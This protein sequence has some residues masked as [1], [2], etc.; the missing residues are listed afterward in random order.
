MKKSLIALAVLA[1]T[2]SAMAQ[3][4]VTLSGRV[5]AALYSLTTGVGSKEVTQTGIGNGGDF[6]LTGSRWA[7]AGT[8]DLGGGL[9]AMFKLENRFSIDDGTSVG[10]FSGDAFVALAG[11]FGTV[12]LGRTYTAFDDARALSNSANVFD[13]A[14]TP[15]AFG[16]LTTAGVKFGSTDYTSRGANGVRYESPVFSGISGAVSYAFDENKTT[17]VDAGSI[18]SLHVKYAAGPLTVAYGYQDQ[19]AQN[20]SAEIAPSVANPAGTA[21]VAAT[22]TVNTK[23]HQLSAA[24]NLGMASVSAGYTVRKADASDDKGYNLGVNVPVGAA[25]NLSAGYAR[26]ETENAAGAT[27]L[28]GTGYGLGATYNMSKS[29]ILYTGFKLVKME[30]GAGAE[31]A[32]HRLMS[33]GVRH[34]F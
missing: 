6:G 3:S 20:G 33:A 22:A 9:K 28:K 1:A 25:L 32:K 8:E 13:S 27:T 11:G 29:T 31:Q 4:S 23:F 12:K 24:Y 10:G 19:K 21:A 7:L 16:Q 26:E 18:L 14:F 34:N 17:T 15:N 2:G 30:D 5:D